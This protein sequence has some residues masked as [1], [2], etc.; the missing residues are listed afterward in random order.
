MLQAAVRS[1]RTGDPPDRTPPGDWV[2]PGPS[3]IQPRSVAGG[4]GG[5]H[6]SGFLS[7]A[8]NIWLR[9][10]IFGSGSKIFGSGSKIEHPMA[11]STASCWQLQRPSCGGHTCIRAFPYREYAV[12]LFRETATRGVHT[13][14]DAFGQATAKLMGLGTS[15]IRIGDNHVS[16]N[17]PHAMGKLCSNSCASA[18]HDWRRS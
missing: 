17:G 1:P 13:T 4:R 3:A 12:Q 18:K 9:S 8:G 16:R 5:T 15:W 2:S 7:A 11:Q 14:A 6:P 10:K